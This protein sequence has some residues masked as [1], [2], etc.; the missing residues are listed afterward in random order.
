MD[1]FDGSREQ[2]KVKQVVSLDRRTLILCG[3]SADWRLGLRGEG[4]NYAEWKKV[5]R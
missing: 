3:T 1:C 2:K 4:L 5:T